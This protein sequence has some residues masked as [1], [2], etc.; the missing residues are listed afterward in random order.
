[1][2]SPYSGKEMPLKTEER[3]FEF[4]K[5]KFTIQF[6][7]YVCEQTGEEF[8]SQQLSELN[9]AQV[10]NQYRAKHHIP[11]TEEIKATRKKYGLSARQMSQILGFGVNM[12]SK[13][14]QGEIPSVSNGTNIVLASSPDAFEQLIEK[15][16]EIS[17]KVKRKVLE[18]IGKEKAKQPDYINWLIPFQN[19]NTNNGYRIFDN[20]KFVNMVILFAAKVKPYKVKMN[21]L[22]F[23]ADFAHYKYFGRS[24]SGATYEAIQMGPVPAYF[25]NL[26]EIS[27]NKETFEIE[28]IW[29]ETTGTTGEKFYSEMA[30]FNENLFLP[31]ELKILNRVIERFENTTTNQI[32]DLSHQ[33]T[34][35]IENI[36][37]KSTIP[38]SYA[39]ELIHI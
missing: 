25:Q 11:F 24:I 36:E 8:E 39:F 9:H 5:E 4:R 14:E 3:E 23:Y 37:N 19:A 12:Y 15:C 34:G 1:M 22:L 30:R 18:T 7:F 38:Y 6:H 20:N 35:W 16:V 33:E 31:S 29:F 10:V 13:Y 28:D 17:D 32:K 21:K 26:F 2:K 27:K